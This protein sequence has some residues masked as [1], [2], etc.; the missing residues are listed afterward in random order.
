MPSSQCCWWRVPI[1]PSALGWQVA[2]NLC[3]NLLLLWSN[4][5]CEHAPEKHDCHTVLHISSYF[6]DAR[7]EKQLSQR[8]KVFEVSGHLLKVTLQLAHYQWNYSFLH[9]TCVL[10]EFKMVTRWINGRAL[11]TLSLTHQAMTTVGVIC[12]VENEDS[13]MF[14]YNLKAFA[15]TLSWR[16]WKD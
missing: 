13:R 15:G 3:N 10:T 12:A 4:H 8:K 2:S 16:R 14:W 11:V 7:N 5:T 1:G 9:V 6:C